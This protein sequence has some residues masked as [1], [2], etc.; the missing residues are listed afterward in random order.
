MVVSQ[1]VNP[2]ILRGIGICFGDGLAALAGA[3][4]A[5]Y[6]GFADVGS[7]TGVVVSGLASLMLGEF[8][9][10]S[11]KIS[12]LTLRVVIGSIIY[13]ALMFFGRSYGYKVGL[14]SND[15]KLVTGVLIILCLIVSSLQGHT[16]LKQHF[17]RPAKNGETGGGR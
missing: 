5:M 10:R 11:N 6:N 2:Q 12:V 9:L 1:G 15:L 16:N 13:R 17:M 3:F 7:G 14:T 8:I 4:A